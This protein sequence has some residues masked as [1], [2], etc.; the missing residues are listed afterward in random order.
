MIFSGVFQKPD[1]FPFVRS[2][3]VLSH[4]VLRLTVFKCSLFDNSVI[5]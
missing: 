1:V 5:L 3:L 2:I 4:S